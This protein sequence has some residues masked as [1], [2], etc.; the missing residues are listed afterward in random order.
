M[1]HN[2]WAL[3]QPTKSSFDLLNTAFMDSGVSIIVDR[4]IQINEPVRLLFIC[5]GDEK[6]M[7]S[8]RIHVDVGE[9]SFLFF[10]SSTLEIAVNTFSTNL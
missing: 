4:D 10:L 8:P 3:S 2:G 7:T 5:S 9:S 1:E 6:L